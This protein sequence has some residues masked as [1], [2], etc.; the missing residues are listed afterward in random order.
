[1]PPNISGIISYWQVPDPI[2]DPSFYKSQMISQGVYTSSNPVTTFQY[3]SG[4]WVMTFTIGA[5]SFAA[6]GNNGTY[7]FNLYL[8]VL[9]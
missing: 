9:N 8:N 5:S 7:G 3:L 6:M 2:T 4:Q 1:V